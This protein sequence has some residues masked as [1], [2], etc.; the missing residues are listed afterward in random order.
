MQ[1]Q[2]PAGDSVAQMRSLPPLNATYNLAHFGNM[3][4]M[5]LA[6]KGMSSRKLEIFVALNIFTLVSV[7]N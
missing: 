1:R 7:Q 3:K 6:V 2:E 4:C 5:W